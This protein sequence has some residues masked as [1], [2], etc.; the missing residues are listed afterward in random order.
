MT[1]ELSALVVT[2]SSSNWL[3]DTYN[4]GAADSV[5]DHWRPLSSAGDGW[6]PVPL[7][8][9]NGDLTNF[10]DTDFDSKILRVYTN[11][12]WSAEV[13]QGCIRKG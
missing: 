7:T 3:V 2:E 13:S 4:R 12:P 6:T 5:V 9:T 8:V 11:N 1:T 10:L